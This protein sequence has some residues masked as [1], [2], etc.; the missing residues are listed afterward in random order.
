M[1]NE[2]IKAVRELVY[3]SKQIATTMAACPDLTALEIAGAADDPD[4]ALHRLFRAI[5]I[6][7]L[8]AFPAW[9]HRHA[10]EIGAP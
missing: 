5:A 10:D 4:E 7:G 1:T 6:A 9:D 3:V 8:L 2:E